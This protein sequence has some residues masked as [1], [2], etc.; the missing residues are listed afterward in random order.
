MMS[1]D[2]LSN[3]RG[4]ELSG[5]VRDWRPYSEP[6]TQKR[7]WYPNRA[8]YKGKEAFIEC[9]RRGPE[10]QWSLSATATRDFLQAERN[11]LLI[12]GYV[13]LVDEK[14]HYVAHATIQNVMRKIGSKEP[15]QGRHGDYWWINENFEPVE[16]ISPH[17]A[18]IPF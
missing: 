15:N 18:G 5:E 13:R 8:Y 14:G 2:R 10:R 3:R 11:Q 16:P 7:G 1:S 9:R 12:Q 17:D 4:A 6:E